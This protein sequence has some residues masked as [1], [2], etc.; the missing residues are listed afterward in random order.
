M[1]REVPGVP[2]LFFFHTPYYG[3]DALFLTQ[4]QRKEVVDT[5]LRAKRAK[6]PVLNSTAGL[7]SYLAGNPNLP[8]DFC[9]IVD[10]RGEYR[11]CRVN[12]DPAICQDCGYSI[13]AELAQARRWNLGAIRA[14]AHAS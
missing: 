3:K 8:N 13:T 4:A 6:L 1:S 11:C 12:G 7:N 14:L 5:L 10:S 2:V 9:R